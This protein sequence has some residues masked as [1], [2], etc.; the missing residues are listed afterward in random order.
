MCLLEK[1]CVPNSPLWL[2]KSLH[3]TNNDYRIIQR[4]VVIGLSLSVAEVSITSMY[5]LDLL[6]ITYN[7]SQ[8]N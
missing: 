7:V 5:V 4:L 3:K 1:G 2:E 8:S 6:G